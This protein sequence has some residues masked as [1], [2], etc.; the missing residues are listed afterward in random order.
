VAVVT[1]SRAEF[2]LLRPVMCAIAAREDLDLL[3]IA[4]GSHL[5]PPAPTLRDV[6]AEF[7][8]AEAVPMQ[9][10]GRH[11]RFD[12]AEAAG[13]GLSRL[14]RVLERRRPQWVVV[15]GDRIEPFAAAAAA[16][17][18]GIAVA[19]VHGGDRA[20]GIADEALR[21][22]ITKLSHLHLPAT[23]QSAERII[24]M[25]EPASLVHAVGSPA[26]DGLE[27]IEPMRDEGWE[28]L[29]APTAVLLLH[30][31]GREDA[32]EERFA[33]AAL[34]ALAGERVLALHP[35]LDPGRSGTLRALAARADSGAIRLVQHLPRDAFI[36]LLRRLAR[37]GGVLVGNSSA[38]LIESAALGVP[39][40]DIG[41]RQAGRERAGNVVHAD[42]PGEVRSALARAR[43]LSLGSLEHPFGDGRAGERIARLLA[44]VDPR[45]GDLRRKRCTY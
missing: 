8:V 9:V 28:P 7:D 34:D 33:L 25:G 20:E 39:A 35:N 29:G 30:P 24:R 12:D 38:G 36:A 1:G 32:E 10:A 22:A 23:R 27:R 3:V 44:E 16:S 15:L 18:A 43:G 19:H 41:L 2:G 21:H 45:P 13:I 40:V 14:A 26:I 11:T 6:R 17:I 4:A 31:L 5:V 42:E 37:S